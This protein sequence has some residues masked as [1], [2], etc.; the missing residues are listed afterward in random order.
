MTV[1]TSKENA[2]VELVDRLIDRGL[3][4]R[5]ELWLTVADVDL[6]FVGIEAIVASAERMR[7]ERAKGGDPIR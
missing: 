2:L 5:G 7:L 1:T 3:V 4:I 6:V